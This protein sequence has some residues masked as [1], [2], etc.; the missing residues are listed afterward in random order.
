MD[1]YFICN[2]SLVC[3]ESWIIL[4]EEL[5]GKGNFVGWPQIFLMGGRWEWN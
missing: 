4:I 3:K 1:D 2:F 5:F